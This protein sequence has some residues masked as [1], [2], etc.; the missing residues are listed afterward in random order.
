VKHLSDFPAE[1]RLVAAEVQNSFSVAALNGTRFTWGG[2]YRHDEVSSKRQWL[3]DRKTGE[4]IAVDQQGVYAQLEAPLTGW[5]R[6]V[7]A[8]RY[9]KHDYYDAQ[10]SPK[11][12]VLITPVADQTLRL[13]FN[14]AFKSPTILQT[15]FFFPDFAPL[16]GV[17]GN[18]NGYLIKNAAGQTLRTISAIEPETNDTWELGYKAILGQ[19]LFVDVTGYYSRFDK[20]MS[21][22]VIIANPLTPA[23][24]GGPTFAFD[25]KTGEQLTGSTG[26]LQIPLTYFNVGK[27]T[28]HGTDV[29]LRWMATPTIGLAGT[30]SLQK[31]NSV[32]SNAGDPAE[33]T[34]FNS[35]TSKF[36]VGMDFAELGSQ[37]LSGAFTVRY[38]NGY[39]FISGVNNGRI[40]TFGTFD[41]TLGVPLPALGSRLNL[42]VQNLF[43]C[44]GGTTVPNGWIAANRRSTYTGDGEC[45]FGKR[46]SE[47]LNMPAI[48]TMVFVGMRFDR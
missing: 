46:H 39:D 19:R 10:F 32:E 5:L 41:F 27:A 31:L 35:P 11:A 38:V 44:T 43:S 16:V 15:S 8:G 20:F 33:A 29:G 17:F 28:I 23:A 9:D 24:S 26:G 2:Q 7:V 47:M 14:R 1:G 3:T 34:A 36:N 21:P 37:N 22:L 18:R 25:A 30:A 42:S 6:A 48:G 13:T 40:P 12:G 4:D 45:G